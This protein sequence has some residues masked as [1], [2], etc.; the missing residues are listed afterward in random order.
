MYFAESANLR[1]SC[2]CTTFLL[3][4]C[5]VT[6]LAVGQEKR[7]EFP[8]SDV[9]GAVKVY[10]DDCTKERTIRRRQFS[11]RDLVAHYGAELVPELESLYNDDSLCTDAYLALLALGAEGRDDRGR[12]AAISC[13]VR[14]LEK[15]MHCNVGSRT[16]VYYYSNFSSACFTSD[17]REP[18]RELLNGMLQ[19]ETPPKDEIILLSGTSGDSALI[20]LLKKLDSRMKQDK[21][22]EFPLRRRVALQACARLGDKE[23]IRECIA[24][25]DVLPEEY[26]KTR[27][28]ETLSYIRQPE[29]V[30]YIKTFLFSDKKEPDCGMDCFGVSFHSRASDALHMMLPDFPDNAS[31][32]EQ[33]KWMSEQKEWK[34]R[35]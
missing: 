1:V 28:L 34:I 25:L 16:L 33:R 4:W 3:G 14:N 5:C 12:M 11:E 7:V 15:E 6:F 22:E 29:A 27:E 23:A 30:E 19:K 35:R 10:I 24:V 18:L 31:L 26:R 9:K 2:L 21:E 8:K 13:I 17:T 32:E 20:P